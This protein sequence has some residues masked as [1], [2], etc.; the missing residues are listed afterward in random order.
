MKIKIVDNNKMCLKIIEKEEKIWSITQYFLC[1]SNC[2][3]N[4]V[5]CVLWK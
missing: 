2:V 4:D 3:G 1:E 5:T